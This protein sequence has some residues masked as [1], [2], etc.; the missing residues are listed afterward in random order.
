MCRVNGTIPSNVEIQDNTLTFSGPLTYDLEGTYACEATNGIG[1]RAASVEV[2][3]I[4]MCGRSTI[5]GPEYRPKTAQYGSEQIRT[6]QQ[7]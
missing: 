4:G 6:I 7:F 3:I 2:V 5:V 1:T